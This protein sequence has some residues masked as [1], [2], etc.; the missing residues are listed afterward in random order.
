MPR[1]VFLILL[2]PPPEDD[3]P[4]HWSLFVPEPGRPSS[5]KYITLGRSSLS[6]SGAYF[7]IYKH[8]YDLDA[9]SPAPIA[10]S[11][12]DSRGQGASEEEQQQ[13]RRNLPNFERLYLGSVPDAWVVDLVCNDQST[14]ADEADDI[15]VVEA[16][17]VDVPAWVSRGESLQRA[18]QSW[19]AAFIRR[20]IEVGILSISAHNVVEN[21]YGK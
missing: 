3:R 14:G 5:G 6:G 10:G 16:E 21:A 20:L 18:S 19:I 15:F 8:G 1:P 11:A 13:T 9:L 7:R 12:D 4:H 17:R 2:S